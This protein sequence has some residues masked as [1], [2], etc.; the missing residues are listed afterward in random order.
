MQQIITYV[1]PRVIYLRQKIG[2]QLNRPFQTPDDIF[3]GRELYSQSVLNT[4]TVTLNSSNFVFQYQ[5]SG[6]P[7]IFVT[8]VPYSLLQS[9]LIWAANEGLLCC[10]GWQH[11]LALPE[12]TVQESS[13]L[14]I[15]LVQLQVH[16]LQQLYSFSLSFLLC[17]P[18]YI[19]VCV[20]TYIYTYTYTQKHI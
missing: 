2:L 13:P 16:W 14:T 5:V 20:C 7:L 9:L 11:C 1:L 4:C 10:L 6:G 12:A 18:L 3:Q 17:L 19:C 8:D 15:I